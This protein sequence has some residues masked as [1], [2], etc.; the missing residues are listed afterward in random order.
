M[1]Q[2]LLL[3]IIVL[4]NLKPSFLTRL[5]YQSLF[6]YFRFLSMMCHGQIVLLIYLVSVPSDIVSYKEVI[7]ILM[8]VH[9][10]VLHDC[11]MFI[12]FTPFLFYLFHLFPFLRYIRL[13]VKCLIYPGSFAKGAL[14]TR[15]FFLYQICH[16][17]IQK[18]PNLSRKYEKCNKFAP[19]LFLIVKFN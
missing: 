6:P 1:H 16:D 4:A 19:P 2:L 18:I 13:R 14:I 17:S 7:D 12:V 10:H 15:K 11:N 8:K 9:Y 3:L 5:I